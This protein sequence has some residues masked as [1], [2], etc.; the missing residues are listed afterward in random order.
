M[1]IIQEMYGLPQGGVLVN[2]LIAQQLSN[3]GYYQVKHTPGFWRHVWRPILFTFVE[4]NFGIC[5]VVREHA[6]YLISALKMYYEQSQQIG[7]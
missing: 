7:K 4:D 5:Y 6:D 3:H 2:N 1:E